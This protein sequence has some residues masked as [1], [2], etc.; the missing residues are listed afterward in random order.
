MVDCRQSRKE[1][2]QAEKLPDTSAVVSD[3]H[4][5]FRNVLHLGG[6]GGLEGGGL[7]GSWLQ[8]SGTRPSQLIITAVRA[9]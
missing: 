5:A 8:A 3:L 2:K 4:P 6:G 7:G 1:I 9:R